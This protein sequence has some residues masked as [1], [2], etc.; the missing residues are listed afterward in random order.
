MLI[1]NKELSEV[2]RAIEICSADDGGCKRCPYYS[3]DGKHLCLQNYG[4]HMLLDCL[5]FLRAYQKSKLG[6]KNNE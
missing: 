6:V 2:I 4:N 1:P 3:K 5:Y